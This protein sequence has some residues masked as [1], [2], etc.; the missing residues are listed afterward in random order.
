MG[1]VERAYLPAAGHD[2]ALPLYDP[3]VSLLGL[4]STRRA[5]L[6]QAALQSTDRVLDVGC[7]T[8]TLASSSNSFIP[9]CTSAV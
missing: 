3:F 7:G 1:N 4:N 2:W 8:G 5:L 9:M 6:D